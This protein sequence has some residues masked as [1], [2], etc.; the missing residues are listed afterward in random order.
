MI[1]LGAFLLLVSSP[2]I[3]VV[4]KNVSVRKRIADRQEA[5]QQ[6]IA[7]TDVEKKELPLAIERARK[8][9]QDAGRTFSAAMS[10]DALRAA[11]SS[12]GPCP[13]R[14]S[15]PTMGAGE[16]YIKHGSIDGNYFGNADFDLYE[17][18]EDIKTPINSRL[19]TLNDIEDELRAG[20]ADKLDLER[21]QGIER[22]RGHELIVV[23]KATKPAVLADTYVPGTLKGRA[24]GYSYAEGRLACVADLDVSNTEKIEI[25][26]TAMVGNVADEMIKKDQAAQT[27]LERDLQ[28]QIRHAIA[29]RLQAVP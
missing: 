19:A 28:I 16:S 29:S 9:L 20:K 2:L 7:L 22:L 21:V 14:I 6:S 15:A 3:W 25:H 17:R 18:E 8:A 24:Y 1:K 26:Y 12:G 5:Y 10:P 13:L 27:T 11:S 4:Y 23:G